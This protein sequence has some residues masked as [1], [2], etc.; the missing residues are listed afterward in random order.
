[1]GLLCL[2]IKF[3]SPECHVEPLTWPSPF[4]ALIPCHFSGWQCMH[5]LTEFEDWGGSI[6]GLKR[7]GKAWASGLGEG[8]RRWHEGHEVWLLTGDDGHR[9]RPVSLQLH[10]SRCTGSGTLTKPFYF[11][12]LYLCMPG[13]PS[14]ILLVSSLPRTIF[15]LLWET[16][17]NSILLF[18]DI[19]PSLPWYLSIVLHFAP[20]VPLT[21]SC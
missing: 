11:L 14:K 9:L 10:G 2:R 1:M 17:V 20:T 8:D 18:P 15:L 6:G 3:K 12:S 13:P 7:K 21:S 4:S 19:L 5:S 16:P